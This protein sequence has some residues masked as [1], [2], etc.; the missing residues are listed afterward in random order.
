MRYDKGHKEITRQRILEAAAGRFRSEGIEAVGVVSLM[1][2]VGLTQGGFYNHFPSKEDLVR[3]SLSD[4]FES[5]LDRLKAR[6]AASRG[7]GLKALVTGYLSVE[8]RDHPERGCTAAALSSEIGRRPDATRA[9]FTEGFGD[10]VEFVGENLPDTL[11]PKQRRALAMAIFASMVGTISL[12]RAVDDPALS[13]EI[14]VAGRQAAISL[15]SSS[16]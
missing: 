2:E 1:N 14:L 9:A 4:G 13:E 12:A 5:T 7:D 3:E 16:V 11:K 8:H 6:V 10:V 15:G